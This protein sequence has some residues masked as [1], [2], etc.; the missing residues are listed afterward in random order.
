VAI[1]L[2]NTLDAVPE[3]MVL[4]IALRDPAAPLALVFALS[5][6]NLPEALCL[7]ACS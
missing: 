2:G 5:V 3:A 1:A 7:R 6:G 4:G